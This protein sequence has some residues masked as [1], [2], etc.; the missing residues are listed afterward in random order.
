MGTSCIDYNCSCI[1]SIFSILRLI[2]NEICLIPDINTQLLC[3]SVQL[4]SDILVIIKC[5]VLFYLTLYL[6]G[7][8]ILYKSPGNFLGNLQVFNNEVLGHF[9]ERMMQ[10]GTNG[11]YDDHQIMKMS[12][13]FV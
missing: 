1:N 12:R 2:S 10:F 7:P 11:T 6:T 5:L 9:T 4:G 13:I 8:L 3:S